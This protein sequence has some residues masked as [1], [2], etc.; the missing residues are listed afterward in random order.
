MNMPS[1]LS[2]E[3]ILRIRGLR[4]AYA[5]GQT[6]EVDALDIGQ[7]EIVVL[8]GLNGAGKSTLLRCILDLCGMEAGRVELFGVSH[9]NAA[10]RAHCAFLSEQFMPSYYLRGRD[11]LRYV[12]AQHG[13]H[14]VE[15]EAR[16]MCMQLDLD[17]GILSRPARELSKGMRQ[18][19][20]L[21]ACFLGRRPLL[22]LDEPASGLDARG[23]RALTDRL[24]RYRDAGGS[25]LISSHHLSDIGAIADR[26]ALLHRGRLLCA[27]R[28]G[29]FRLRY[30]ATGLEDAFL[31]CIIARR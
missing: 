1:S 16:E 29:D 25:A 10:A 31:E 12:L 2:A 13:Q 4:H 5:G 8:A 11:V 30:G 7:R 23:R 9:R 17:P 14:Y 22:L 27:D 28:A 15:G 6:L 18:K 19:L 20:G 21:A 24:V 26:V 3:P